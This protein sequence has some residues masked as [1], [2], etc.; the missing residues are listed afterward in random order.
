MSETLLHGIPRWGIKVCPVLAE[1]KNS[2]GTAPAV[3]DF[4]SNRFLN[5]KN[6]HHIEDINDLWKIS[7]RDDV[8]EALRQVMK[9]TYDNAIIL[10]EDIPQAVKDIE[11]YLK[12]IPL[13]SQYINHW[14]QIAE[15]LAY[16]GA[17]GKY[18]GFGFCMTT[19]GETPFEGEEFKKNGKWK[20]HKISWKE[21]G[22]WNIYAYKK[23]AT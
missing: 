1:Y 4:L 13:P 17:T 14:A 18:V 15:D 6:Y 5:K 22:F 9:M 16:Y 23:T 10:N 20:R 12:E 8:P 2:H 3:W 7:R 21:E 19:I 11:V